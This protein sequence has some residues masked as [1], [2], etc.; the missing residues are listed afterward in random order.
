MH[1]GIQHDGWWEAIDLYNQVLDRAIPTFEAQFPG[2]QALF[3]FDNATSHAAF[4]DDA[5]CA[6][7]MNLAPGGKQHLMR[8]TTWGNGIYQELVFPE[9]HAIKKFVAR[10]RVSKLSLKNEDF[11]VQALHLT[12]A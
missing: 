7:R 12:V 1:P 2:M 11:G 5:L 9:D 6:N 3:A 4:A 8:Q 10:Q